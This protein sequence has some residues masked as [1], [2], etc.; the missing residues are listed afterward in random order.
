VFVMAS[1]LKVGQIHGC[2][3]LNTVNAAS[4]TLNTDVWLLDPILRTTEVI[5]FPSL[6]IHQTS[7]STIQFGVC[8]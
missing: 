5:M 6:E 3:F 8:Q 7:L 2:G 4:F 1:R